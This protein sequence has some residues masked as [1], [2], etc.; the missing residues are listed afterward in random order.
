MGRARTKYSTA[1][2]SQCRFL[3]RKARF[4]VHQRAATQ[5]L[6]TAPSLPSQNSAPAVAGNPGDQGRP[7]TRLMGTCVGGCD[8]PAAAVAVMVLTHSYAPGRGGGGGGLGGTPSRRVKV[9]G[10]NPH[11]G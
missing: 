8:V 4:F 6:I 2:L 1:A 11:Q 3:N 9:G 5:L 7:C 10:A